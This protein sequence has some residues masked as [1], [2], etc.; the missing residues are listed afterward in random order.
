MKLQRIRSG[1]FTR[2][3]DQYG[4]LID[5]E[6]FLGRTAFDDLWMSSIKP[7]LIRKEYGFELELPLPGFKKEEVTVNIKNDHLVL[8]AEKKDKDRDPADRVT[9]RIQENLFELSADIDQ[10]EISAMME[11]G[12]LRIRLP[13]KPL[14]ER[15]TKSIE[16]Q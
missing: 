3:G 4:H 9:D 8:N 13:Q 1:P 10:K 7:K 2:I 12:V 5:G 16:V 15:D 11:D 14:K 6:H